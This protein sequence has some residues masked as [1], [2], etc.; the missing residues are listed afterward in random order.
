MLKYAK[1]KSI[2]EKD[3]TFFHMMINDLEALDSYLLEQND[4]IK[5]IFDSLCD[6]TVDYEPGSK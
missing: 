4:E 3:K 2:E 5:T 6:D 1:E